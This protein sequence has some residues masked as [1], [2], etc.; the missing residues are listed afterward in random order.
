MIVYAVTHCDCIYESSFRTVSLHATKTGAV[1]AM[2]KL[3]R[4]RFYDGWFSQFEA[5]GYQKI[6][7]EP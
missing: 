5:F 6:S 7:I 1:K 4:G 2:I 3:R